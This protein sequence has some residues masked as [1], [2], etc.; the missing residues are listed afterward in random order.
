MRLFK[1]KL[2]LFRN[3]VLNF[4]FNC[5]DFNKTKK[6]SL[7]FMEIIRTLYH[8]IDCFSWNKVVSY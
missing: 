4:D 8:K 2:N 5:F 7:K 3:K 6:K 1:N